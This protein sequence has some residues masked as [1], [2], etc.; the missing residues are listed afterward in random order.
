M[1]P[2]STIIKYV[3]DDVNATLSP[4]TPIW[5]EYGRPKY[6]SEQVSRRLQSKQPTWPLIA[7]LHDIKETIENGERTATL[8]IVFAINTST[9]FNNPERYVNT[10]PTVYSLVDAFN[11]SL[12]KS[13]YTTKSYHDYTKID[14]SYHDGEK[15]FLSAYTDV[16]VCEFKIG[17]N[18]VNCEET[19]LYYLID[20]QNGDNG[21]ITPQSTVY[22]LKE[23]ETIS[24]GAFANNGYEFSY[25]LVNGI[26]VY[27]NPLTIIATENKTVKPVFVE[28]NLYSE[29]LKT[30]HTAPVNRGNWYFGDYSGKDNDVR[31]KGQ[32][33]AY[34]T[35]QNVFIDTLLPL[36]NTSFTFCLDI[37]TT[38]TKETDYLGGSTSTQILLG[39]NTAGLPSFYVSSTPSSVT[40]IGTKQ[41]K[42]NEF[43]RTVYIFDKENEKLKI[44][45]RYET[46]EVSTTG[47]TFTINTLTMRISGRGLARTLSGFWGELVR[48]DRALTNNEA[49]AYV[50][51]RAYF[52]EKRQHLMGN[53][54]QGATIYDLSGNNNH[55][56]VVGAVLST[57]WGSTSNDAEPYEHTIGATLYRNTTDNS[58]MPICGDNNYTISG[59]TRVGYFPAGSGAL[60]GLPNKYNIVGN[61]EHPAGDY[62]ADEIAAW[63][64]TE[65]TE[66][67]QNDNTITQLILKEQL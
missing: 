36:P 25:F 58:I 3:V 17:I 24:V 5:Y 9:A 45:N 66:V 43:I 32:K 64:T 8:P 48:Y 56:T 21:T 47:K 22:R 7:L 27:T 39:N 10:F 51:S 18:E 57:F 40:L 11:K 38:S 33:L 60:K 63:P 61:A 49:Q 31:I 54:G 30:F 19:Q 53:H 59:F 35:G 20:L 26:L 65:L 12:G 50:D 13:A 44:I 4:E 52:P 41:N 23:N 14:S 6:I 37:L 55:G 15:N 29:K 28:L 67:T 34:F 1:T 46:V 42:I 16:I 2:I 62:T